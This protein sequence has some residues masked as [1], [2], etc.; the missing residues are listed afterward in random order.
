M[1]SVAFTC[2]ELVSATIIS[3]D[4]APTGTLLDGIDANAADNRRL[5]PDSEVGGAEEDDSNCWYFLSD[6]TALW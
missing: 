2:P 6:H 1:G 3:A 5:T 4:S